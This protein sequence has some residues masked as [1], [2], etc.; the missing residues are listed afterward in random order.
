MNWLSLRVSARRGGDGQACLT[1]LAGGV[2]PNKLNRRHGT[3]ELEP[4]T[5]SGGCQCGTVK[6]PCLRASIH[7]PLSRGNS[8]STGLG[9]LQVFVKQNRSP[10][11]QMSVCLSVRLSV[12]L[13][14]GLRKVLA[15]A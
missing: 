4:R 10:P 11:P 7:R 12:R 1:V 13:F 15:V 6:V 14:R 9:S 3:G 8:L 2:G 5:P